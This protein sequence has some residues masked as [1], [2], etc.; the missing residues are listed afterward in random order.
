M[1]I[2]ILVFLTIS[3]VT[4]LHLAQLSPACQTA[5]L[6]AVST[7]VT[8]L[9]SDNQLHRQQAMIDLAKQGEKAE[10]AI[11][12]LCENLKSDN[13]AE[14]ALAVDA[15]TAIGKPAAPPVRKLL[16]S[17]SSV[18]R[19]A[20]LQILGRLNAITLSEIKHLAVDPDPR[21]RAAFAIS[22][23]QVNT[24]E[25]TEFLKRLLNDDESSVAA[26][27]SLSL[28]GKHDFSDSFV[29]D[30]S[31]ALSRK[32]IA[33]VIA[34]TLSSLG[35]DARSAIPS[36][37]KNS[38]AIGHEV[39][40]D[41]T[42]E[43]LGHIGPPDPTDTKQIAEL[44]NHEDAQTTIFVANCISHLGTDGKGAA[45]RLD[46][47]IDRLLLRFHDVQI[48][49]SKTE[50]G[51]LEEG[52][53][54]AC[55]SA[56]AEACAAA[57]L[58]VTGNHQKFID[59]I[60]KIALRSDSPVIFPTPAPWEFSLPP[61]PW[62]TLPK[63]HLALVEDLLRSKDEN[64]IKSGLRAIETVGPKAS[65]LADR[66][67]ELLNSDMDFQWTS[68]ADSLAAMGPWTGPKS[69]PAL[70]TSFRNGKIDLDK[71]AKSTCRT[72]GWSE[73]VEDLFKSHLNDGPGWTTAYCAQALCRI[74][75]DFK[76]AA[77]VV[78][79]SKISSR[80]KINALRLLTL[81]PDAAI[82]F[83][84]SSI[85]DPDPWARHEAIVEISRFN[86]Q[87]SAAKE[88]LL[89]LLKK[90]THSDT[91][92][93]AHEALYQITG[94]KTCLENFL[95]Q[96]MELP[97]EIKWHGSYVIKTIGNL[98]PKGTDF[99]HHLTENKDW[100][101]KNNVIEFCRTLG[102]VGDKDS[103]KILLEL[104]NSKD[105]KT[106]SFAIRALNKLEKDKEESK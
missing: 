79:D 41:S 43:A 12:Q 98:G 42:E 6:D 81:Q 69:F 29:T 20:A 36:I 57:Y 52:D 61:N 56:A 33:P 55:I 13:F 37:L 17:D 49:E 44:L 85:S 11:D 78:I 15:L 8:A 27:A 26:Q 60:K 22:L 58:S 73:E 48:A 24:I 71:F 92:F 82:E 87:C 77:E 34:R 68:P 25:S 90:E 62:K 45:S 80:Q 72:G 40:T 16:G 32:E 75:E 67:I 89:A 10:P 93:R 70:A 104:R 30:L 18:V 3:L 83:Y 46:E 86:S 59:L 105:W 14:R 5:N 7:L 64:V 106:K 91:I 21:V 97:R 23:K 28:N 100:F 39:F 54:S 94:D 51:H 9:K 35:T 66:V 4:F 65:D 38:K 99:L 19:A 96:K 102:K 53:G 50:H 74:T 103:R 2:R 101:V 47:T 84:I 95:K 76:G 88:P 31:K 63:K 1:Q